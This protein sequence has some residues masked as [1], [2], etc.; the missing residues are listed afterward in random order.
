MSAYLLD[1]Q[2]ATVLRIAHRLQRRPGD[3]EAPAFLA[4][5]APAGTPG[6]ALWIITDYPAAQRA[7][8]RA[9]AEVGRLAARLRAAE[10]LA[11][12]LAGLGLSLQL[13]REGRAAA[14]LSAI[15]QLAFV[16]AAARGAAYAPPDYG[17]GDPLPV[18]LPRLRGDVRAALAALCD[19]RARVEGAARH[20]R[21]GGGA[22]GANGA[23]GVPLGEAW[24]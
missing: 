16:L 10:R 5:C 17:G 19:T 24:G 13:A 22:G 1:S 14:R 23:N 15:L 4:Q 20:A 2:D 6:E 9:V 7:I 8:A 3:P 11:R 18:G 12:A 21:Q